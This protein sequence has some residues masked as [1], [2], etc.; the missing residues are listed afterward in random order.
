MLNVYVNLK[1]QVSEA[2]KLYGEAFNSKAEN[3]QYFKDM[4]PS[5]EFKVPEEDLEKV[6]YSQMDI[7]GT[8]IMLSDISSNYPEVKFGEN[9][10][11]CVQFKTK[12]EVQKAFDVLSKEG[13]ITM[14][15]SETFFAPFYGQV[16]DKF[17]IPWSL[18][19]EV[20]EYEYK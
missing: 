7:A 12:E 1:G 19:L 18:M 6:M 3:V 20:K 14:P 16:T 17:G 5:E 9:I 4:P 2:H 15:L 11:L 8:T 13:T 10:N